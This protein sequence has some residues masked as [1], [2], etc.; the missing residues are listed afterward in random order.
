MYTLSRYHSEVQSFCYI[1]GTIT[2]VH[3]AFPLAFCSPL[4]V[5]F[6]TYLAPSS[7]DRNCPPRSQVA[8]KLTPFAHPSPNPPLPSKFPEPQPPSAS[9]RRP[10]EYSGSCYPEQCGHVG[11][12]YPNFP[13]TFLVGSVDKNA[14]HFEGGGGHSVPTVGTLWFFSALY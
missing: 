2:Y 6:F 13:S 1:H 10:R 7:C 9:L 12:H 5:P 3:G 8:C 14:K 4:L 11:L